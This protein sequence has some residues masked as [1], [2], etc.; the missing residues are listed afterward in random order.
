MND[1]S[2][3]DVVFIGVA[4]IILYSVSKLFKGIG[5]ITDAFGIT[6]SKKASEVKLMDALKPSYYKG[7]KNANIMTYA[8]AKKLAKQIYDA[9]FSFFYTDDSAILSAF[10]QCKNK[11]QI[12]FLADVFYKEYGKD[13][14]T[15][16]YSNMEDKYLVDLNNYV[17]S[18]PNK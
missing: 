8:S 14:V 10:K 12:S 17:A 2:R 7:L 1:N 13:L 15:Y 9:K 3:K 4:L 11:A 5:G 16:F 18:I 6:S